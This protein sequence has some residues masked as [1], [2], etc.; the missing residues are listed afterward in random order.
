MTNANNASVA[1][2]SA[3]VDEVFIDDDDF[4]SAFN[5]IVGAG[6]PCDAGTDDD[7]GFTHASGVYSKRASAVKKSRSALA[8][9]LESD[10]E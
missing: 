6:K 8:E 5:E 7:G 10:Y 3:V 2:G 9:R 4:M 1:S